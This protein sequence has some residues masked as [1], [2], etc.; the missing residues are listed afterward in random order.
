MGMPIDLFLTRHGKSEGNLATALS[1]KGDD[2]MF[3]PEFLSRHS[4]TWRLVPEG[5]EQAKAA[6]NWIKANFGAFFHRYYVSDYDRA[7]ETAAW[8]GLPGA[9][10]M[11]SFY[12]RERDW[13]ELDVMPHEE[14]K[15]K[16]A[17]NLRR[18]EIDPFYWKPSNG[19][20]MPT[21]CLR[22]EKTLETLHRECDMESAIMVIHGEVMWGMR[23]LFE[24]MTHADIMRFERSKD[25]RDKIHNGQIIHYT[26]RDPMT[27]EIAP[28]LNWMRSICPTDLSLSYNNWQPIIRRKFSNEDLLQEV[29]LRH[30][31]LRTSRE[32]LF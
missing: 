18:K 27:G 19:E 13:G 8:L 11:V 29:E 20:P 17:E 15:R 32:E 12:L 28:Y 16:F 22:I 10:W 24:R 2:S 26:R 7:K 23:Y 3:T 1:K 9:E 6:G 31:L 14:R 5:I 4:S 25:P 30:G 21:V